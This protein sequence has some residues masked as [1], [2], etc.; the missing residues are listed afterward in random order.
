MDGMSKRFETLK[1]KYYETLQPDGQPKKGREQDARNLLMELE[2]LRRASEFQKQR[3]AHVRALR[4]AEQ[5]K[6]VDGLQA[7][8]EDQQRRSIWVVPK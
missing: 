3:A 4:N 6:A 2:S 1:Q 5:S 8:A 7:E